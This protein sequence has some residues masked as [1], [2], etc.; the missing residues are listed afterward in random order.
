MPNAASDNVL[1]TVIT[2]FMGFQ[3]FFK[4]KFTFER[5]VGIPLILIVRPGMLIVQFLSTY[6][7]S[8]DS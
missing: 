7:Y 1:V 5:I 4:L 8:T 2:K 6:R 3:P